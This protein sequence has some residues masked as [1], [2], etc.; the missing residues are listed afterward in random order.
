MGPVIH[1]G[2]PRIVLVH[3]QSCHLSSRQRGHRLRAQVVL[4]T[5]GGRYGETAVR[6]L[7]RDI[8]AKE[9]FRLRP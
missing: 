5:I 8:N 3:E 7:A 6:R 9:R 2:P 4:F 1:G